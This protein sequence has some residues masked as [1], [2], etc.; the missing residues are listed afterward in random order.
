MHINDG[1]EIVIDYDK[2]GYAL[3][4]A[5][6]LQE[7]AFVQ[8]GKKHRYLLD[9]CFSRKKESGHCEKAFLMDM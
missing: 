4:C 3:F 5:I 2:S 1:F 8:I 7:I 9:T 6:I